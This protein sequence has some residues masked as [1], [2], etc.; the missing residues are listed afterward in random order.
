MGIVVILLGF[1]VA[2]EEMHRI[3]P[4]EQ[5]NKAEETADQEDL[6][7][8]E[9]TEGQESA[10]EEEEE[11]APE[12]TKYL[13]RKGEHHATLSYIKTDLAKLN[14]RALFDS[15]AIY[16]TSLPSNQ[17]D[18]N[19][20]YGVSDC[21]SYHHTNSARFGWRWYNEKLEIWAYTYSGGKRDFALMDTV[22]FDAFNEYEI[23]FLEDK[24]VF[25]LNDKKLEMPR[26]C[27]STAKGYKLF[28]YFGG[29]EA[30]PQ[31]INILIEELKD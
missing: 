31:D 17:G 9:E 3:T 6:P 7:K 27:G 25:R 10:T 18:I 15:S 29:D 12:I 8:E 28:P 14:F 21:E 4:E 11:T 1:S 30:A 26:S 16:Q 19:K 23:E 5:I 20:L 24:Y 2:C 13:I 22:G